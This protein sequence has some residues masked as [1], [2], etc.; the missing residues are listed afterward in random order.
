MQTSPALFLT[1]GGSI[2][3]GALL[4]VAAISI[5]F[6]DILVHANPIGILC[7]LA[8]TGAI[9]A[10]PIGCFL[11][12][13]YSEWKPT[14]SADFL[15]N[16]WIGLMIPTSLTHVIFGLYSLHQSLSKQ[17]NTD[18]PSMR[19]L[20]EAFASNSST[21]WGCSHGV[22]LLCLLIGLAKDQDQVIRKW[23]PRFYEIMQ[24]VQEVLTPATRRIL[25][26][27]FVIRHQMMALA[28]TVS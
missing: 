2:W 19:G 11:Y 1:V 28:Y 24:I 21:I 25:D 26:V 27:R 22:I 16:A 3:L 8:S 6:P 15:V 18:E 14:I 12:Q 9:V 13:L 23:S 17:I 4:F 5:Y 20:F 7:V 10:L